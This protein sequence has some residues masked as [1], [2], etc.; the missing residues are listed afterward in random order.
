MTFS[1][2]E[3]SDYFVWSI[4]NRAIILASDKIA[5]RSISNTELNGRS[6]VS[7]DMHAAIA[8]IGSL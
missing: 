5:G 3:F 8:T 7:L 6:T 2:L 1:V 4:R